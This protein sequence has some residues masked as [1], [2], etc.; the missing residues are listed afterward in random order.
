MLSGSDS[1][2]LQNS[3]TFWVGKQYVLGKPTAKQKCTTK[4]HI[5]QHTTFASRWHLA[6]LLC[7][8]HTCTLRLFASWMCRLW[9]KQLQALQCM[10]ALRTGGG[11]VRKAVRG[12]QQRKGVN[13][14]LK[15]LQQLQSSPK[16]LLEMFTAP[17]LHPQQQCSCCF[18]IWQKANTTEQYN[19]LDGHVHCTK[20]SWQDFWC[21]VLQARQEQVIIVWAD[22]AMAM[23][24]LPSE[25]SH[26]FCAQQCSTTKACAQQ[27]FDLDGDGLHQKTRSSVGI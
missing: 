24:I 13:L 25:G 1:C 21:R 20:H 26:A 16:P 15:R 10:P 4:L 27:I 14:M 12:L 3:G 18:M 19:K 22:I 6:R 23:D 9:H 2:S 11:V 17:V 5:F 7:A 8:L